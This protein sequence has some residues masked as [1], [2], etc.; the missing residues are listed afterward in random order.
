M[1]EAPIPDNEDSRLRKL[2]ELGILDTLEEQAYDD[3]TRLAA[4]ICGT[5][6][7]LVSLIDRDRQ[8]FKSHYG[9][10]ARETPR[11]FAF[12][13]HAIL[14]TEV[15]VVEDSS[16]DVRFADNPLATDNPHVVFY[17]G[18]PLIM[19]DS[20]R[21]GTLCVIG[22]TPRTISAAQRESLQALARQ[23]VSQLE[24]RLKLK[25]LE[26]LDHSKDEFISMV[27]HELRTPLTAIFGSLSL[28]INGKAGDLGALQR[29]LVEISHRNADRLIRLVNDILDSAKLESGKFDLN[30]QD[31]D[32][33]ELLSK[34]VQLNEPYCNSL[35][36]R[37][38]LGCADHERVIVNADEQRLL[39]VMSN[40]ISNAAKFGREGDV[41]QI[42]LTAV[43][44]IAEVRVTDHGDGIPY[45]KQQFLFK[46]FKQLSTQEHN[47]APGTGLGLN[48]CK[49]MIE[50]QNG[51][52]GFES[53]PNE[54]TTFFFKLPIVRSE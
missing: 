12:C 33:V 35:D 40:L 41:I 21:L 18:A 20:N 7:S 39:Q 38:A 2:H 26:V 22:D 19:S 29:N 53:I 11:E 6:I 46:K 23:V 10:D 14:G 15:F 8:W 28:L 51:T 43:N 47:K 36:A 45:D 5:P 31:V 17:A 9:L 52:I 34:S 13:A 50:L 37:L 32:L 27:S 49:S 44:G 16:K 4:E 54:K 42:D 25:E 3:L 30:L 24:L 1:I 48:I